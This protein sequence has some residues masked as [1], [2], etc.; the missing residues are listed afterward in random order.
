MH[1]TVKHQTLFFTTVCV[2]W[3]WNFCRDL[4]NLVFRASINIYW[5]KIL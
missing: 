3:T 1:F 5:K 2:I 4:S